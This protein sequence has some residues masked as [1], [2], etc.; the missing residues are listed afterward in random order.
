M[1]SVERV[2]NNGIPDDIRI[3]KKFQINGDPEPGAQ[4]VGFG[5]PKGETKME[6]ERGTRQKPQPQV[7]TTWHRVKWA[8]SPQVEVARSEMEASND[9]SNI[10]SKAECSFLYQRG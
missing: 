8:H 6:A 9:S 7:R 5:F 3:W 10:D 4:C 1:R 2:I